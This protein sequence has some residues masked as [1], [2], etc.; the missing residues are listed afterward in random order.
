MSRDCFASYQSAAPNFSQVNRCHEIRIIS[1]PFPKMKNIFFNTLETRKFPTM[2]YQNVLN[3]CHTCMTVISVLTLRSSLPR[4]SIAWFGGAE[5]K[6]TDLTTSVNCWETIVRAAL[7]SSW[8]G[9]GK[10]SLYRTVFLGKCLI[11]TW[12]VSKSFWYQEESQI[13]FNLRHLALLNKY[14][15]P[16]KVCNS[17]C[18]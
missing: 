14:E 13:C 9:L 11:W 17:T 4:R 7:Y 6:S 12:G 10:L 1:D 15:T 5:R 2:S 3:F 18:K 16:P 8:G